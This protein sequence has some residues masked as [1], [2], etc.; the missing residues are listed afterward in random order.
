MTFVIA[1]PLLLLFL[2]AVVDLGR[3]VFLSMALNDAAHAACRVA[4]E[5][6]DGDVS[7]SQV[8]ESAFAAAPALEA[9]GLRLKS[10]VRYGELEDRAYVHRF[11]DE[12]TGT[13]DERAS[14]TSSRT[15]EVSL[16]LEGGYLTPLGEAL[17]R[18]DGAEGGRFVF[19]ARARGVADA[20]VEGGAW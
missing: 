17:A 6:P 14:K 16:E 5:H 20:T 19:R 2:F 1:L 10:S 18:A 8:R 15:V 13:F 11:Y 3:S 12:A 7:P 9:E 4:R